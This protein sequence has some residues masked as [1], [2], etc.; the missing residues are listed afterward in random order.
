MALVDVFK[1]PIGVSLAVIGGTLALAIIV[2]LLVSARRTAAARVEPA[3]LASRPNGVSIRAVRPGVATA[4]LAVIIG[5]IVI[6]L[7]LAKLDSIARGP[8]SGEAITAISVV[9]RKLAEA[10]WQI[11]GA[12]NNAVDAAE[13]ALARAWTNLDAKRYQDSIHAA[14]DAAQ[15]LGEPAS[16]HTRLTTFEM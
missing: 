13:S 14:Q 3:P 10:Q 6:V 9:E 12:K 16:A 11:S 15:L 4:L 2:S 8:T 5:G 7:I 1:I